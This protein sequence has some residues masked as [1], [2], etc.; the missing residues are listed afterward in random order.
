M[1]RKKQISTNTA[2]RLLLTT[3]TVCLCVACNKDDENQKIFK[4]IGGTF[5]S[6]QDNS[7][8]MPKSYLSEADYICWENGDTVNINGETYTITL[9]ATNQ[10]TIVAEGVTAIEGQYY[11]TYPASATLTG[12]EATFTLPKEEDY[13]TVANGV[14]AGKQRLHPLMAA[15][16]SNNTMRFDNLCALMEFSITKSA[17]VRGSLY[18]IEVSSSHQ[19]LCGEMTATYNEGCWNVNTTG[20]AGGTARRLRFETPIA[21]SNNVQKFYMQLPPQTGIEDFTVRYYILDA[22]GKM[23][24]FIRTKST[25]SSLSLSG[26]TIY[27]MDTAVFSGNTMENYTPVSPA[28]TKE[29]PYIV[30]AGGGWSSLMSSS[31]AEDTSTYV[32]LWEDILV[33]EATDLFRGHLNGKGHTITLGFT[34]GAG[35][36]IMHSN[37]AL[38]KEIES[39]S[40]SNLTVQAKNDAQEVTQYYT[41][42]SKSCYGTIAAYSKAGKFTNCINKVNLNITNAEYIGGICGYE[43]T[44]GSFT[45]CR[46]EGNITTTA[47]CVGGIA[48]YSKSTLSNCTNNGS[49]NVTITSGSADIG[50]IVG[51]MPLGSGSAIGCSNTGNMSVT[52]SNETGMCKIGGITGHNDGSHDA[53]SNTGDIT[54]NT[55]AT[56]S[57]IGG[58]TGY[59]NGTNFCNNSNRST[60]SFGST[61]QGHAGGLIGYMTDSRGTTISNCYALSNMT[62]STTSGIVDQSNRVTGRPIHITNCYYYGTLTASDADSACGLS[63]IRTTMPLYS[64]SPTAYK[65][66]QG[67]TMGTLINATTIDGGESLV[68]CL[69]AHLSSGYK[70]WTLKDG[71]VVHAN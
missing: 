28:G 24:I 70:S 55:N 40:I 53:C 43:E 5:H 52:Y 67:S 68:D 56:D 47:G 12:G 31:A 63:N 71:Y 39:A 69:N 57:Y 54:C 22:S 20:M 65:K 1:I 36:I 62:G 30:A 23:Q 3:L 51:N 17:S 25:G 29:D 4:A 35:S 7:T 50:G 13:E 64:Y 61:T 11:A 2:Y 16:T 15:A 59:F 19:Q 27:T 44:A 9:D 45:N 8:A 42:N 34:F 60:L 6:D 21:L 58:I 14:G 26:A 37:I 38:F 10:A 46:N 18:A 33:G 49:I 48:S 41:I 32:E 66:Q